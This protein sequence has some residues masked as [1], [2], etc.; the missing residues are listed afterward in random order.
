VDEA[1]KIGCKVIWMQTGISHPSA[2]NQARA[3]GLSVV[4]N[5]CLWR[6]HQAMQKS[7]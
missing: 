4:E 1:L 5:R 6:V 7:L 2:A 3:A